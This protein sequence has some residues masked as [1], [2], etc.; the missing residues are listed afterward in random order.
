MVSGV[1]I[2]ANLGLIQIRVTGK[3]ETGLDFDFDIR[4]FAQAKVEIRTCTQ[5]V[6]YLQMS[7]FEPGLFISSGS[8][9]GLAMKK[10][11]IHLVC[12]AHLDPVW[13]WEWE[14]GA[15]EAMSTFR[16]AANFCDEFDGF[17]FN[18]NEVIL[19]Q[20]IEEY[21]P[22]LFERIRRLV[23]AGRWHIMGGWYLQPD[24]NLPSGE[25]LVRQVLAG[26]TY[27]K[28]KFGVKPTTA[29]NFDPFGHSR[30]LVQ[31]LAKSGYDSYLFC[32]PGQDD[33]R[34][35]ADQFVWVGYDGSQVMATRSFGAYM[36]HP[37][38]AL[39][40]I[41]N[42][43]RERA[44]ETIGVLLWGVGNHGGGPSR[45]DLRDIARFMRDESGWVI[46]HSTP[47][48]YFRDL[49]K[50]RKTLPLHQGDLN[51]WAVGCYT[52]MIRLKR[53]HRALENEL[54]CTEKMCVAAALAGL[55]QYPRHELAEAQH[56]LLT[57]QFHDILPGSSIEPVQASSLRM[58]EHGLE[59]LSRIKARA[60]FALASGQPG[61]GAGK[62]PVLVY[63][64][65]PFPVSGVFEVEFQPADQNHDELWRV[66]RITRAGKEIPGQ[67][68]TESSSLNLDWRK[69]VAFRATLAPGRMNRFD[70]ELVKVRNFRRHEPR[71]LCRN[72]AWKTHDLRVTVNAATGL[73]DGLSIKGKRLLAAGAGR[74]LVMHD[75]ADPWGMH[76]RGFRRRAGSF[77]LM[78]R[79][80]A[81]RF[82][83]TDSRILAPIRIIEQ[84][85]VRT[86]VEAFFC[87]EQ[88][89]ACVRYKLPRA[90]SCIEIEVRILWQ[91]KDRMLKL[92]LPFA[93]AVSDFL[94]QAAYGTQ[95]LPMNG[96]EAVSQQWVALV[97]G[98]GR[99]ALTVIN[100]GTY[101]SDF[102]PRTG[103]RLSLLRSPAYS[104]HPIG[105]KAITP[106]DRFV[107]RIDQGEHIFR[108]WLSGGDS[109][110][111]LQTVGRKAQAVNEAPFVLSFFPP[112][113]GGKP[114][115]AI[116][117]SDRV[118]Q[119]TA[120]KFAENNNDLIVRLF[121]P[122]GRKRATVLSIPALKVRRKL[123]FG[124][125]EIK[126]LR[127][128]PRSGKVVE[129]GLLET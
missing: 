83:G 65:H 34:L 116:L 52:S 44:H 126:T 46:V 80:Q 87:Y 22:R 41:R 27:F 70:C 108:F 61:A 90:G 128:R 1:S 17:V 21:E 107:P 20:W 122:T 91:E 9:R 43:C 123:A 129:T 81:A 120:C 98:K 24:C 109:V 77:R 104:G 29:I 12:N 118:I 53:K 13:L 56:D 35:E 32:R 114:K 94:G 106:Q 25:S 58:M 101:G 62:I 14:E 2:H 125:F 51:P 102:S 124:G 95:A 40:K 96:D 121:E 99:R 39:G 117:L 103:L 54:Y 3:L 8:N 7:G 89:G 28:E 69:R 48:K 57:S 45:R 16:A 30:G 47:E 110:S 82:S 119:V 36:T 85:E 26:N 64:P 115:P 97:D 79:S 33:C 71:P 59:I 112:G 55:V 127:I 11:I 31:I 100:D 75:N 67:L 37:G 68:E 113:S 6:C 111:S 15:A 10:P 5:F 78:N 4:S 50:I 49:D 63:N 23:K 86:V 66:P 42:Y 92:A 105:D 84:G 38:R 88:S 76:V 72:L 73:L 19:Y 18:H 93:G 60:F 74:L